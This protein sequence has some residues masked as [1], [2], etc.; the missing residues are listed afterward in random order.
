[1]GAQAFQQSTHKHFNNGS[2][3][4]H[5]PHI[6]PHSG[7]TAGREEKHKNNNNNKGDGPAT[8]KSGESGNPTG[9]HGQTGVPSP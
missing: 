9:E 5:P 1:M 4:I 3:R 8:Q 7:T 2:K 6:T